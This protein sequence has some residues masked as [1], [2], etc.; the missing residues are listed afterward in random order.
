MYFIDSVGSRK[1]SSSC[2]S[3]DLSANVRV[4]GLQMGSHGIRTL[5]CSDG[6]YTIRESATSLG[7]ASHC[8]CAVQVLFAYG[9]RLRERSIA[10]RNILAVDEDKI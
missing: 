4:S 3:C 5:G 1:S 7:R 2:L 9:A 8:L 10:S 6:P